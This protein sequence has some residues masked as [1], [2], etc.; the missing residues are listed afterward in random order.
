MLG[1]IIMRICDNH[2][3]DAPDLRDYLERE[4]FPVLHI[5]SDYTLAALGAMRTRL[6]AFVETIS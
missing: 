5:E 1:N 4:G 2:R 3:Y 6:Q